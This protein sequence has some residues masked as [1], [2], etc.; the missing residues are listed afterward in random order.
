MLANQ[1]E[2]LGAR[3]RSCGIHFLSRLIITWVDKIAQFR[4]HPNFLKKQTNKKNHRGFYSF[5]QL[6]QLKVLH[7][8][9]QCKIYNNNE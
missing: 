2:A 5:V 7:K 8:R 1:V 4:F 3:M 9:G 6:E